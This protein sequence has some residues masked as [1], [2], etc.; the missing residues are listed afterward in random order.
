MTTSGDC[1]F[2]ELRMTG[3]QELC[4]QTSLAASACNGFI[5]SNLDMLVSAVTQ[6]CAP[7]HRQT[8]S[9]SIHLWRFMMLAREPP[10]IG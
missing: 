2:W 10:G 7:S 9:L 5:S 1:Q 3:T 8:I 6:L 4:R